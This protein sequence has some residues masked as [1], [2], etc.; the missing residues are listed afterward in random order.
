M[1]APEILAQWDEVCAKAAP[2]PWTTCKKN[3]DY[4][5]DAGVYSNGIRLA[6]TINPLG[7]RS[8]RSFDVDVNAVFI[9]AARTAV[10]EL[11]AE[12]RRLGAELDKVYTDSK[13][14]QNAYACEIQTQSQKPAFSTFCDLKHGIVGD[15]L[16]LLQEG[17]ISRGK[18]AESL[19]EIAHGVT[20]RIPDVDFDPIP[21]DCIPSKLQAEIAAYGGVIG[22]L[23]A[24]IDRIGIDNAGLRAELQRLRPLETPA[25]GIGEGK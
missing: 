20:P 6:T 11:I 9:A 14:W 3:P 1:I 22:E 13:K 4:L 19:A 18:A 16:K 25:S 21:E 7:E 8:S 23:Q 24:E 17:Q 5:I 10:P 15:I 12:V 2:E